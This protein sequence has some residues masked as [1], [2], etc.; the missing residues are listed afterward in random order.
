MGV[1]YYFLDLLGLI[2]KNKFITIKLINLDKIFT[3]EA[4]NFYLYA[5]S[6]VGDLQTFIRI[7]QS[8]FGY[9]HTFPHVILIHETKI[10]LS[11]FMKLSKSKNLTDYLKKYK[12][13]P[14]PDTPSTG[15]LQIAVCNPDDIEKFELEGKLKIDRIF[16]AKVGSAGHLNPIETKV[17]RLLVRKWA[18]PDP[19]LPGR[20]TITPHT[21]SI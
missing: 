14:F 19:L 2:N 12:F 10:L 13:K 9:P 17:L 8:Y 7:N 1:W 4:A 11:E 20:V 18:R 6:T 21:P 3:D 5:N 16:L 15:T